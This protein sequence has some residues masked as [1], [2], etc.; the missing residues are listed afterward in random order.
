[1]SDTLRNDQRERARERE[2]AVSGGS[3]TNNAQT[4]YMRPLVLS[5]WAMFTLG[6][7]HDTAVLL[8]ATYATCYTLG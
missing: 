1:M 2:R 4:Q 8:P 5:G 7:T 3:T 6:I